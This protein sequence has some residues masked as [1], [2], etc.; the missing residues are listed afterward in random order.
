MIAADSLPSND[1]EFPPFL[2]AQHLHDCYEDTFNNLKPDCFKDIGVCASCGIS[3]PCIGVPNE[4]LLDKAPSTHPRLQPYLQKLR[5]RNYTQSMTP[6]DLGFASYYGD[7]LLSGLVLDRRGVFAPT[8]E[9]QGSCLLTVCTRCSRDLRSSRF[10]DAA[11]KV[12]L[13]N[14]LWTGSPDVFG[15]PK[16]TWMDAAVIAKARPTSCILKLRRDKHSALGKQF[17]RRTEMSH[18]LIFCITQVSKDT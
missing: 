16:L 9:S 17:I 11:P 3:F 6:E 13:A 10:S 12:S 1:S 18:S 8:A 2:T 15:L 7:P 14:G 4:S 5:W